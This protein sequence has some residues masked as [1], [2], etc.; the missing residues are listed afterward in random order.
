MSATALNPDP[1]QSVNDPLVGAVLLFNSGKLRIGS[2]RGSTSA[3]MRASFD[4]AEGV[5]KKRWM[6]ASQSLS[7][8][9]WL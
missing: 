9:Y 5:L 6:K 1:E 2:A 4:G 7:G 3:D 8:R